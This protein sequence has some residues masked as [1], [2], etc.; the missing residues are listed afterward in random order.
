MAFSPIGK[1]YK[2]IIYYTAV[3]VKDKHGGCKNV[4]K[5]DYYEA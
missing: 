3:N 5:R 1:F 2:V 4:R